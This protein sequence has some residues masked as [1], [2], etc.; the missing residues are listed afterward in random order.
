[1]VSD[2]FGKLFTVQFK[3]L[4]KGIIIDHKFKIKNIKSEW[5]D[6]KYK[7]GFYKQIKCFENLI[8]KGKLNFPGQVFER[9]YQNGKID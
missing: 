4:E 6:K 7:P 1:M 9:L 2:S 8:L 5:F 3:P